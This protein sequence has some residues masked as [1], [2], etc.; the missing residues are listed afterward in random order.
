[1]SHDRAELDALG[2]GF[3]ATQMNYG[4]S[5]VSY[6]TMDRILPGSYLAVAID[7]E[8]YRL[9]GD[10]DLME[11]ARAAATSIEIHEGQTRVDLRVVRLRRFVQSSANR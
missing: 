3:R 7:V 6:Y 10:T 4:M 9:G 5:G 1:M 2:W 8:P 11:R